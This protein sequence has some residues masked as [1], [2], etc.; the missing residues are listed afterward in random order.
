MKTVRFL[1]PAENE[2]LEAAFYYEQQSGGLGKDFLNKVQSA[3]DD[4]VQHPTRWPKA[5]ASIRRRL[6]HRFPYVI[7][8]ENQSQEVLIVA[9]MHLRRHPNYW[10]G[11]AP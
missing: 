7:L 8:Y 1:Q 6:V 11:R 4:I 9:V 3:V 2:M 10:I 5:R